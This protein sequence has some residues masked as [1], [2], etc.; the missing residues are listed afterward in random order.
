MKPSSSIAHHGELPVRE[1]EVGVGALLLEPE[2]GVQVAAAAA[3][4]GRVPALLS[5][6]GHV[7]TPRIRRRA[8]ST[9]RRRP[10]GEAD[11]R[12]RG[13]EREE[14]GSK[15]KMARARL[16]GFV[17]LLLLL[18]LPSL[19]LSQVARLHAVQEASRNKAMMPTCLLN[20]SA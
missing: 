17:P 11:D 16:V 4:A 3:L 19:S 10:A 14:R 20:I 18:P 2:H 9:G 6:V 13:E 15:A 5:P 8:S 12:R 1:L 7:V